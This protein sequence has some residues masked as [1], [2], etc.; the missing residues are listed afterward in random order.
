MGAPYREQDGRL[1]V[2][3]AVFTTLLGLGLVVVC[4]ALAVQTAPSIASAEYEAPLIETAAAPAPPVLKIENR[5]KTAAGLQ[6]LSTQILKAALT[7]RVLSTPGLKAI[8]WRDPHE[9]HDQHQ[10]RH[11]PR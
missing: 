3:F 8:S 11:S 4:F 1:I 6:G 2:A 10:R 5:L 9:Q 7:L